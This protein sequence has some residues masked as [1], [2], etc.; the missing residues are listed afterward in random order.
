MP[1]V[2]LAGCP[3]EKAKAPLKT[4]YWTELRQNKHANELTR[5]RHG[6]GTPREQDH[7]MPWRRTS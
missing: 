5:K 2:F 7:S 1:E 4:A 6:Q 3:R